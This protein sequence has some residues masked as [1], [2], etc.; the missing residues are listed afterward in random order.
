MNKI[1]SFTLTLFSF[2]LMHSS[3]ANHIAGGD[4][5]YVCL[6]GNQYQ[7]NLNLFVDCAA[8]NPL[9]SQQ[10]INYYSS[11]GGSSAVQLDLLNPGGTEISQLCPSQ[12]SNSSCNG[13]TLPGMRIY[14]YTGIII[15]T[16]CN[17]W[18]LSWGTCCRNAAVSNL[19]NPSTYGTYLEAT[20]HSATA[21]CNSS[22]SFTARSIPYVCVNQLVN[23][24]YGVTEKDG[25]SLNFSLINAMAVGPTNLTYTSGYSA[26]SPI[27]GITIDPV[28]GQLVFTPTTIGNFVVVIL[29]KEYDSNGNL[30]GTVMRDLQFVVQS[31][32]NSVPNPTAG[33]ITNLS[34]SAVQTGP[35]SLEL[36][37][38]SKFSFD[39]NY[40]DADV[41]D[42]LTLVSNITT[43]LPG[44]TFD[45]AGKNPVIA[46]ISWTAPPG[47]ANSKI[48]FSVTVNDGSCPIP[49]Q[50]TFIYT[51]KITSRTWAGPD[52]IIC[53]SQ[54][55]TLSGS[56]GSIFKWTVLN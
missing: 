39:A 38:G 28:T 36:C 11:C 40:S 52:K 2:L 31:C 5:T 20:L 8:S 35:Y 19:Q 7:V 56:G 54:S 53:R 23:Y 50:Q 12:I 43:V 15:L 25:D 26:T 16:P 17:T 37:E 1:I 48:I 44:A 51:L 49:I 9:G 41:G 22:P 32:S 27:P 30:I 4:L 45:T 29:V 18:T 3:R 6:G 47:S 55:A 46:H 10:T 33:T 24:N 42:K 14:R 34:G 21:S 13:G